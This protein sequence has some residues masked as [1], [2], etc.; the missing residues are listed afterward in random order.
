VKLTW[1]VQDDGPKAKWQ[2]LSKSARTPWPRRPRPRLRHHHL[3]SPRSRSSPAS[4]KLVR[5]RQSGSLPSRLRVRCLR[6]CRITDTALL[7]SRVRFC[8][9]LSQPR[10]TT[11]GFTN[12]LPC[13]RHLHIM[14]TRCRKWRG[15]DPGAGAV[16]DSS[17]TSFS[18]SFVRLVTKG[19]QR[20]G[21]SCTIGV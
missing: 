17:I 12:T 1:V 15:G 2:A 13:R 14:A 6:R 19:Y 7:L 9:S 16:Y 21:S 8:L 18:F 10:T 4:Q 11:R 3:T 5:R 20:S